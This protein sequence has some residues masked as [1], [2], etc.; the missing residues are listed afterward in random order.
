MGGSFEIRGYIVYINDEGLGAF[1]K[2]AKS[3]F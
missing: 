3:D 1:A 2:N